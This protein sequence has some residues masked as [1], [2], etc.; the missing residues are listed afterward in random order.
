MPVFLTARKKW[1]F[2]PNKW[3]TKNPVAEVGS[4][5]LLDLKL[6]LGAKNTLNRSENMSWNMSAGKKRNDVDGNVWRRSAAASPYAIA[7]SLGHSQ[8]R[9]KYTEPYAG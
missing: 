3:K 9:R 8:T 1:I 5:F 6:N 4:H 7:I 2:S